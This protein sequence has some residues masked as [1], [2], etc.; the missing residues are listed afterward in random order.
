M[1]VGTP[2]SA[3]DSVVVQVPGGDETLQ[4]LLERSSVTKQLLDGAEDDAPIPAGETV[5]TA[6][7]EYRQMIGALYSEGYYGG[8]VSVRVDGQEAADLS[9]V[10]PPARVRQ[11]VITVTPGRQFRFSR[12]ELAPLAAGTELPEGYAAGEIARTGTIRNAAQVGVAAWRN[13]GH[14]KVVLSEE[15]LEANHAQA[16]LSSQIGI[17]PGPQLRFGPLIVTG[18]ERVRTE[19]I[20]AIAGLPEGEVYDP[21]ELDDAADRLRRTGAFR[22]ITLEDAEEIGPNDTLPI[23]A[24]IVEERLRRIG[25][26]AEISSTEG[27]GVTAYWM[28]RNLFG[29]AENLRF[30]FDIENIG[31]PE[32]A[33][34][35][36]FTLSGT[37][38][39]PATPVTDLDLISFGEI[40]REDEP[41]YISDSVTLGTGFVYYFSDNLEFST[42]IAYR[43]SRVEDA[44]GEREFQ[45]LM[46]PSYVVYDTRDVELDPTQ[47]FFVR[48]DVNPFLGIDDIDNGVHFTADAR[49]YLGF[50]ESRDIVAAG[51]VQL[52][53]L[54]GPEIAE[55]PPDFLFFAGGGG[56]VRGQPYQS[57]GVGEVDGTI[58]GGRSYVA[59][60][61][62]LR[63]YVRGPFGVVGFVDA[64]YVGEE[65]FYDGSGN[66]M[67]GAG[68]GVRYDTGFGPIRVDVATPVDGGPDDADPVQIYIGIG[69]AF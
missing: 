63:A 13:A 61:A 39:R 40:K 5:S 11:V 28:H 60:S 23:Q 25:G 27:V 43:A 20:I 12:A 47:G 8:T 18:N 53:S 37:F 58:V 3:L 46:A 44:F 15:N 50:G 34:G 42:A 2:A 67:S 49:A 4:R 48:A 26:G 10:A 68:L 52:G 6:R 9:L 62:E 22:A 17:D 16:V 64:G 32:E 59:L 69:Q 66:W 38:R 14:A 30:D 36:D 7:S 24:Q 55:A 51:R 31:A 56:S 33:N 19:R 54:F 45:M 29:G 57:L 41:G 1:C 65:E 21:E 35:V